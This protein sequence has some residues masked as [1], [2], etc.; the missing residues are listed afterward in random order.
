MEASPGDVH[1]TPKSGHCYAVVMLA[2]RISPP[3]PY[4]A[5]SGVKV[6]VDVKDQ[7]VR[8]RGECAKIR[9]CFCRYSDAVFNLDSHVVAIAKKNSFHILDC[10]DWMPHISP[11]KRRLAAGSKPPPSW[12]HSRYYRY[13][14]SEGQNRRPCWRLR[15]QN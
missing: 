3:D 7:A 13:L 15:L 11:P 10:V 14:V 1:F 8:P 6:Y 4:D 9:H 12:A 5:H 2:G